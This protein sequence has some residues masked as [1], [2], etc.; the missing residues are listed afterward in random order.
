MH[1]LPPMNQRAIHGWGTLHGS[2]GMSV[3]GLDGEIW[4]IRILSGV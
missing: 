1:A 4:D 2:Q 3:P